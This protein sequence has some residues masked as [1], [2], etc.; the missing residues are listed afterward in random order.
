MPRRA[1]NE[2]GK[3]EMTNALTMHKTAIMQAND[4]ARVIMQ[5]R[6]K[7]KKAGRKRKRA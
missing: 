1:V 3:K 5:L 7:S 6:S 2:V 4:A